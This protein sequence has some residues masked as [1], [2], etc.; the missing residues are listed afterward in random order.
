MQLN[1]KLLLLMSL[2]FIALTAVFW[3]FSKMLTLQINEEWVSRYVKKQIVFDKYRTLTPIIREMKRVHELSREPSLIAMAKDE[4]DPHA[5]AEGIKTLERYRSL[6]EDRSYFAAFSK[7]GH[8]Y[9]N[10]H[11]DQYAAKQLQYTL[12]PTKVN[13]SWFYTTMNSVDDIGINVDKD[14]VLGI[15]KIWINCLL[16]EGDTVLGVVGTGFDF[17]QFVNESVAFEQDGVRN[18]FIDHQMAIQL[19]KEASVIDYA[20]FT[21]KDGEHKTID[22]L[23]D[24]REDRERVQQIMDE[25]RSSSENNTVKTVWVTIDG[26]KQLV[27]IVYLSEIN[28]YN[29]TIIDAD[30]LVI[31]D[32]MVVFGILTVLLLSVLI[33]LNRVYHRLL[34]KPINQLKFQMKRIE[35]GEND[36]ELPTIGEGEIAELSRQFKTM[37]EYVRENNRRLE[38]KIQERTAVLAH[39]EKKF[40]TLFDSTRDAVMLLDENGFFECNPATLAIFDCPNNEIFSSLHPADLS[41]PFQ[42]NGVESMTLAQEHIRKA[43]QEGRD[44]FEWV[45]RRYQTKED[46]YAEVTL[47]AVTING[48]NA[49]QAMVRDISQRK[50]DEAAIHQL[51][52]YDPLTRLPNRRLLDER[53]EHAIQKSRRSGEKGAVM[54]LDLDNFKPLN[55]IY[56]HDAGD[57]LLVESAQRI[58]ECLR[59]SDTVARFG[60]DEFVIILEEIGDNFEGSKQHASKIADKILQAFNQNFMIEKHGISITHYCSV[61]I[62]IAVFD[63]EDI[64]REEI[65]KQADSA[66]YQAKEYGR[67]RACFFSECHS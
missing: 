14:A 10:D 8:Y 33:V 7:T 56:G 34:I 57:I 50:S 31:I 2:L 35:N 53:M 30:E 9:F 6:F 18:Y 39:S 54:F 44:Q 20:S 37:I 26:K 59:E 22:F 45:H 63:G 51:A 46:F 17:E 29:L 67:N 1:T 64:G 66:M 49:L 58:G 48:R 38:D 62:G 60:G 15:T 42:P 25:V 3:Q 27:G 11:L 4:A 47:N 5:Y 32:N 19:A 36:L 43:L 61:S 41:P 23:F 55:D 40:R 24:N 13:D 28:W 52:F 16:K 12:S 21:K 65:F